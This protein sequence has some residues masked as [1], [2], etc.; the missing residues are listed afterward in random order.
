MKKLLAV[1]LVCCMA[2]SLCAVSVAAGE[3]AGNVAVGDVITFGRYPQTAEGTDETP[4]EWIV[5]DVQDGKALL[6]S[7]YG[8]DKV[9]YNKKSSANTWE[10]CTLRTWLNGEFLSQ[11]FNPEEQAAI[12]LTDVDNSPSQ[13]YSGWSTDGGNN[14]QDQ[15]FLLSYAE[16]NRY[17]GVTYDYS[18]NTKSRVAPTA[19]AI[20]QGAWTSDSGQTADGEPAGDWWLRS[21]GN[22]QDCAANVNY[23]GSLDFDFAYSD[24]D[25]V[26]PAL[27]IDLE[28][29][30]LQPGSPVSGPASQADEEP[31]VFRNG[32]T[33]GM[34]KAEV[35][36]L[37]NG[38]ASEYEEFGLIGLIYGDV[39][40]SRFNGELCYY[41]LNDAL[42][43]CG[44]QVSYDHTQESFEY[45]KK[46]YSAKYGEPEE[47]NMESLYAL[48][49][50]INPQF[51]S[52]FNFRQVLDWKTAGD[53]QI[54][55][56]QDEHN[57]LYILYIP[58]SFNNP[59]DFD[60]TGI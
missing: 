42:V 26:R 59:I 16:A 6:L 10:Q 12:R 2:V 56:Y 7:K 57:N 40:I 22:I 1:L 32:I 8:L 24:Y 34:S 33:W 31:F 11:A 4:I 38:E 18:N 52:V 46:A 49:N 29:E 41:F 23:V 21:P 14:T 60:M 5:L 3:T 39:R 20:A 19:Y 50:R 17:L 47:G 45:L 55:M 54:W 48:G 9:P 28:S 30:A 36:A 51:S 15:V 43:V 37:E 27:W 58:D 25:V 44:Y 53:T 35:M 13:G